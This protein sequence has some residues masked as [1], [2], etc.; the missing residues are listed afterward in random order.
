MKKLIHR[1]SHHL[2]WYTGRV[3]SK[4]EERKIFIGFQCDDCGEISGWQCAD[5]L[6]EVRK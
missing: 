3:V 1:L 6:R 4:I 5:E 2:G